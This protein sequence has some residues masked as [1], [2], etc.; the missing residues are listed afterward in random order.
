[1]DHPELGPVRS[2]IVGSDNSVDCSDITPILARIIRFI[3]EPLAD[4]RRPS[5]GESFRFWGDSLGH[6]SATRSYLKGRLLAIK[7]QPTH[8]GVV[9]K[10]ISR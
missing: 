7:T 4:S 1:M 10:T 3:G 9:V 8:N 2:F 6:G 5:Q